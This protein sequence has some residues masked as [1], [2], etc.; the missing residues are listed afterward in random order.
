M[1]HEGARTYILQKLEA[2]LNSNLFY[3]SYEHTLDVMRAA[4]EI[5]ENEKLSDADTEL[6]VTAAAYHD[7][8]F[9]EQYND[10]EELA[11]TMVRQSLPGFDYKEESV[12]KICQAIMATRHDIAPRSKFEE[13][14]C[15]ADS[16]YL[17]RK[18]YKRIASNLYRELTE[19]GIA[20]NEREWILKQVNHLWLKHEYYTDYSKKNRN[21]M[22]SRHIERL[23]EKIL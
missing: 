12:E 9:L 13:V 6:V 2:E 17:G 1:N 15:D 20:L 18:D 4:R 11:C 5:A 14:L 21:S 19:H 16:D 23:K 7:A 22:K 8:G 10:N 3:H